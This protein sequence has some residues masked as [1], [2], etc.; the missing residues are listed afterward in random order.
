V[1]ESGVDERGRWTPAFPGQRR[2]FEDGNTLAMRHGAYAARARIAADERTREISDAIFELLPVKAEAFRMTCDDTAIVT[3]RIER[4]VA[5][6][7]E[8]DEIFRDKPLGAYVEAA[9][10][11]DRLRADLARWIRL[12]QQLLS[13]LGLTPAA[14]VSLGVSLSANEIARER[15]R[16]HLV[17]KYGGEE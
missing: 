14:Q 5:G 1:G 13:S 12:R 2:P 10:A 7:S 16:L 8:A 17:E 9:A 11:V 6:I 4:A 3:R 15:L